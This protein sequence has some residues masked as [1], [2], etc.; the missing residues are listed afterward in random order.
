MC[1][2]STPSCLGSSCGFL[3]VGLFV[4]VVGVV[5]MVY[6]VS[7]PHLLNAFRGIVHRR[8]EGSKK[9]TYTR[10]YSYTYTFTDT[11]KHNIH[12]HPHTHMY[13]HMHI[14]KHMNT[15]MH[16]HIHTDRCHGPPRGCR[17]PLLTCPT[18]IHTNIS[19][20]HTGIH[21]IHIIHVLQT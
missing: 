11:H 7:Y 12:P 1:I 21:N 5:V 16:I 18:H 9:D 14:Y 15:H 20:R 17:P 4:V 3:V 8:G 2:T 13:I 19:C 10:T 6:C